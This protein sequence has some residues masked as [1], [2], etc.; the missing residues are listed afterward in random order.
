MTY[1]VLELFRSLFY[2]SCD[3][4]SCNDVFQSGT[5]TSTDYSDHLQGK[6]IL[7]VTA[8]NS[9]FALAEIKT[10]KVIQQSPLVEFRKGTKNFACLFLKEKLPNPFEQLKRIADYYGIEL[11][12][13]E[14]IELPFFN[15]QLDFAPVDEQG[16][17]F[18][19]VEEALEFCQSKVVTVKQID[20]WEKSLPYGDAPYC[21]QS[22][23]LINGK[24]PDFACPYLDAK[25]YPIS[26]KKQSEW[27]KKNTAP[28]N[29]KGKPCNK[30][31]CL[32]RRY[33]LKGGEV[34]EVE[35]GQLIQFAEEPVFYLWKING[36]DMKFENENDIISQD[37]FLRLCMRN[38]GF[39]PKKLRN[40]RWLKIINKA[41]SNMKVIGKK[42]TAKLTI[43]RMLEIITKDLKDRV[44]VSAYYE[45]ERLMQG[46]IYL[47]PTSSTFVVLPSAFCSYITG[48]YKDVRIENPT[49]FYAVMKHLGFRGRRRAVEGQ[50]YTLLFARSRFL[51]RTDE[52]W[53]Q[54]LL[55]VSKGTMWEE[56][57]RAFLVD[58]AHAENMISK[59]VEEDIINDS[60]IFLDTEKESKNECK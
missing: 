39:L 12:E 58:D 3:H 18:K 10:G 7:N 23:Y 1:S 41:L 33:G 14:Y 32:G 9:R 37:R 2:T 59:E 13:S 29:C 28:Y 21:I 34:S 31:K 35:F 56:N 47:D 19:Y 44:L 27:W 60:A 6:H 8:D 16:K 4:Y 46:Y 15:A 22:Y 11:V 40:D 25:D 45:Y 24:L 20:E 49:D 38:L 57:F 26:D 54:F 5:P 42:E 30:N 55:D 48:K 53:S 51:F 43:D 50:E 36:N 17:P 52:E